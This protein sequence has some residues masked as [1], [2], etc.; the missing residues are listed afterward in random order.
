MIY[1]I[2]FKCRE[3]IEIDDIVFKNHIGGAWHI[4]DNAN[5]NTTKSKR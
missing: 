1:F 2:L 5:K 4:N 3:I